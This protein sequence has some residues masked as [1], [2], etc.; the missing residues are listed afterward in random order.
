M[1]AT[2]RGDSELYKAANALA[3][4]ARERVGVQL[5]DLV[6][7]RQGIGSSGEFV[8]S[9]RQIGRVQKELIEAQG[10]QKQCRELG[11]PIAPHVEAEREARSLLRQI[12]MSTCQAG[13]AWVVAM[14]IEAQRHELDREQPR[15][16]RRR[17]QS[18]DERI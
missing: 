5:R 6:I 4:A 12:V 8:E 2:R 7:E 17:R 1:S 13:A 11:L 16:G 3:S 14:D 9:V 15:N 18:E 10:R